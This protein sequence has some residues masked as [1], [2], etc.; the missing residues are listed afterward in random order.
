MKSAFAVRLGGA[1]LAF[2]VGVSPAAAQWVATNG[3]VG[4]QTNVLVRS[5]SRLL[6]GTAGG[7]VFAAAADHSSWTPVNNGLT[8]TNV[9]SLAVGANRTGTACCWPE[10]TGAASSPPRTTRTPGSRAAAD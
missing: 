6:A 4:A 2:A 3:P 7:G 1:A 5:G 9:L 10:P 8:N